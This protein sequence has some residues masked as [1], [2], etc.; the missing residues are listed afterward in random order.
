M[1]SPTTSGNEGK[2]GVRGSSE[3]VSTPLICGCE[4]LCTFPDAAYVH[5]TMAPFTVNTECSKYQQY[6]SMVT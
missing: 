2:L 6:V 5:A 4:K 3:G 1:P